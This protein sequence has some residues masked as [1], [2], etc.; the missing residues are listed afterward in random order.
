MYIYTYLID[1]SVYLYDICIHVFENFKCLDESINS[2]TCSR[3][4]SLNCLSGA[5]KQFLKTALQNN[6]KMQIVEKISLLFRTN[7]SC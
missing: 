6:S 7:R 3:P 1:M 5:K 4:F 2:T